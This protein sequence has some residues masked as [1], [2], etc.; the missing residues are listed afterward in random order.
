MKLICSMVNSLSVSIVAIVLT[1]CASTVTSTGDGNH[2]DTT[3]EVEKPIVI[4]PEQ[5]RTAA[6]RA[7]LFLSKRRADS[8]TLNA[9]TSQESYEA[10]INEVLNRK[11]FTEVM[12]NYHQSL[13]NGFGRNSPYD[14][15]R[16][17]AAILGAYVATTADVPYSDILTANYCVSARVENGELIEL[18]RTDA[19]REIPNQIRAP[20]KS[21]VLTIPQLVVNDAGAQYLRNASRTTDRFICVDY[22]GTNLDSQDPGRP[23]DTISPRYGGTMLSFPFRPV[24]EG[25]H[26]TDCHKTLTDRSL[27]FRFF[28]VG[29]PNV[30]DGSY[31]ETRTPE[32][33]EATS[34][35]RTYD[36]MRT[37]AQNL[38]GG[39]TGETH[40]AD[41]S[42]Y[43]GVPI[44]QVWDLGREMVKDERFDAC[45][46][47]RIYNWIFQSQ[48]VKGPIGTLNQAFFTQAFSN[49]NRSIKKLIFAIMTNK[50]VFLSRIVTTGGSNP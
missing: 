13:F 35:Y 45:T 30:V 25:P 48:D 11:E 33:V 49:A 21:G 41:I 47:R 18:Q 6:S 15:P 43:R 14:D 23:I 36:P 12:I 50:N 44:A 38:Q 28:S 24:A 46:T 1:A 17:D 42:T 40:R 2:A 20:Q 5:Y 37:L 27:V 10:F 26:C 32:M 4:S 16:N 29:V 31:V 8:S 9:I 3:V 34:L 7:S 39:T 22:Q 19:C